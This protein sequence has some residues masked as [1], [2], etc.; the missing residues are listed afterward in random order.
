MNRI[1]QSQKR[2]RVV[3]VGS[4]IGFTRLWASPSGAKF[5]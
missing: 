3:F 5:L 4:A 1:S 2:K